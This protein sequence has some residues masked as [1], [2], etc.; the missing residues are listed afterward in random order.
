MVP[1][2]HP[3]PQPTIS[4]FPVAPVQAEEESRGM[5][6]WNSACP[7]SPRKA[8]RGVGGPR[9]TCGSP[10]SGQGMQRPVCASACSFCEAKLGHETQTP[11]LP[12]CSF[13][14]PQPC[15]GST[16]TQRGAESEQGSEL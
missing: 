10:W 13:A 15:S 11:L 9:L 7:W 14:L 5:R 12:L 2:M 1:S 3:S 4:F 8:P 6:L 16:V